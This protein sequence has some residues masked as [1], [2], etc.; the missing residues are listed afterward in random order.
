VAQ[1]L[2]I[3]REYYSL[4]GDGESVQKCSQVRPYL[5]LIVKQ[6]VTKVGARVYMNSYSLRMIEA[7]LEFN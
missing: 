4:T 1:M 7:V 6:F 3:L 2:F 5:L